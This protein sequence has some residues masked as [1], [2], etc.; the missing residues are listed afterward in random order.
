LRG[1]ASELA[2]ALEPGE[3]CAVC[4]GTE[5]PRPARA[6]ADDV[7]QAAEEEAREAHQRAESER[8]EAERRLGG[9]RESLAAA[10]AESTDATV[11]ELTA[12]LREVESAHAEAR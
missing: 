12:V 2:A 4:G 5:H 7:D 9:L 6:T 1:I 8:E 3:P 10:S 11:A